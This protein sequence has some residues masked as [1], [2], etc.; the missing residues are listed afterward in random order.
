MPELIF[1]NSNGKLFKSEKSFPL[2][3]EF[4]IVITKRIKAMAAMPTKENNQIALKEIILKV[5]PFQ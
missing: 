2:N 5:L 3:E 1:K 4:S